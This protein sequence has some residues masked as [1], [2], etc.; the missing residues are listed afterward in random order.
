MATDPCIACGEE[1]AVGSPLYSS[2]KRLAGPDQ[3]SVFLCDDCRARLAPREVKELNQ[4][5][6]ERLREGGT[7]FG[8]WFNATGQLTAIQVWAGVGGALVGA[9]SEFRPQPGPR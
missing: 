1:T 2:R 6:Q 8:V 3:H 4:D 9:T 7:V 5:E